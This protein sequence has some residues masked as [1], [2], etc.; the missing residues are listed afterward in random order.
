MKRALFSSLFAALFITVVFLNLGGCAVPTKTPTST[1]ENNKPVLSLEG[2]EWGLLNP[3]SSAPEQFVQFKM[4]NKVNGFGGCN[5]FF[6]SYQINATALTIGPL[7]STRKMCRNT[8]E[9]ERAFLN[10]LQSAN[11][12]AYDGK[13][14]TLLDGSGA[15]LTELRRRDWD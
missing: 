5:N 12:F 8:I 7:A 14:L 15:V 3:D 9:A 2:S 4:D 1:P 10:A 11:T 6:G 13:T